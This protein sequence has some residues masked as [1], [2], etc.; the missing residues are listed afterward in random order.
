MVG[1][2]DVCVKQCCTTI[3]QNFIL[4]SCS[5]H[6]PSPQKLKNRNAGLTISSINRTVY[7]LKQWFSTRDSFALQETFGSVTAQGRAVWC[8]W[9]PVS[10]GQEYS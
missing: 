4:L 2:F 9:Q 6:Y 5:N 10:R 1:L 8:P 3:S 7:M